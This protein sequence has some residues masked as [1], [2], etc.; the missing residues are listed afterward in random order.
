MN[1]LIMQSPP[2]PCYLIPLRPKYLTL[3]TLLKHSEPMFLPHYE[4]PGFTLL[5]HVLNYGCVYLNLYMLG[6]KL[7]GKDPMPKDTRH[8]LG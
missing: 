5:Q 8:I 1:L 4:G 7:E 2:V 6:R 3:G